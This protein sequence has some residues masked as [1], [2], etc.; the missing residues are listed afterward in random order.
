MNDHGGIRAGGGGD[1]EKAA[2][3]TNRACLTLV[4][5]FKKIK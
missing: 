5:E 3:G 4:V 2:L 1:S